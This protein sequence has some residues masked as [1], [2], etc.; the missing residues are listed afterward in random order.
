M[1]FFQAVQFGMNDLMGP[2]FIDLDSDEVRAPHISRGFMDG[3]I[4]VCEKREGVFNVFL[5][6]SIITRENLFL[7]SIL[8]LVFQVD[9]QLHFSLY[10]THLSTCSY[11]YH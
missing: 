4:V 5:N 1:G 10:S 7:R 8:P 11:R 6:T 2:I 3:D 9:I